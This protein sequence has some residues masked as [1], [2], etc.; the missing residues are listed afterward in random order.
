MPGEAG[1]EAT[2]AAGDGGVENCPAT[3]LSRWGC[4]LFGVG[5]GIEAAAAAGAAVPAAAAA[6]AAAAVPSVPE[7]SWNMLS[8]LKKDCLRCSTVRCTWSRY[9]RMCLRTYSMPSTC[10]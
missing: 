5:F 4:R 2:A 3:A 9:R 7:S 1:T 10:K 6:A 8:E